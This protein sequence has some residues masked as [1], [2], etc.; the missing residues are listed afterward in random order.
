MRLARHRNRISVAVNG[1]SP[2]VSAESGRLV[3]RRA[4]TSDVPTI[5]TLVDIYAGKI[6]L[7]KNL[8]NLY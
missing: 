7:E 3:V 5:K 4:R 1:Y 6:L 2:R 8:V